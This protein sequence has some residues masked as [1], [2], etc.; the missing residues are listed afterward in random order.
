MEP[1]Y[2]Q[3]KVVKVEICIP[4]SGFVIPEQP[5]GILGTVLVFLGTIALI[6]VKLR[7]R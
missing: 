1:P 2:I 3:T 7:K 6:G 5:L 4:E